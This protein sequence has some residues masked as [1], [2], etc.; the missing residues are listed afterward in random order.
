MLYKNKHRRWNAT[1]VTNLRQNVYNDLKKEKE[2]FKE[3]S[4]KFQ[5]EV[6]LDD[7]QYRL[8]RQRELAEFMDRNIEQIRA[9]LSLDPKCETDISTDDLPAID[10]D[11][12]VCEVATTNASSL[13]D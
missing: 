11:A 2:K 7:E 9:G 10:F 13:L 5:K 4:E 8:N 1:Q 12:I 3:Y 6:E